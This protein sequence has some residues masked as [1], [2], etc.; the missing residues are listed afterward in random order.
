MTRD[1]C[2]RRYLSTLPHLDEGQGRD[3]VAFNFAAWLV[4][5]K[6]LPDAEALDWLEQWDAGN[7]PPKGRER[8]QE[9]IANAHA[10]GRR[11]YGSGNAPGNGQG[12]HAGPAAAEA[13]PF[14][15]G[16]L[17]LRL[18]GARKTPSRLTAKVVV[19]R[20]GQAIDTLSVT[21]SPSGRKEPVRLLAQHLGDAGVSRAE[22]DKTLGRI[23]M[24]ADAAAGKAGEREGE[25]ILELVGPRVLKDF[26]F[27]YRTE[28]GAYSE[29]RKREVRRQEFITY[30]PSDLV[31][32]CGEA[33]DA[34]VNERGVVLLPALVKAVG[35][36][37]AVVW[38]DLQRTLPLP[39]DADLPS[40]TAA[41]QA[42]RAAFLRVWEDTQTWER[43]ADGGAKRVNLARRA[44]D[45][46]ELHKGRRAGKMATNGWRQILESTH[47]WWRMY[48]GPDGEHYP[49]LAMRHSLATQILKQPLP[50]V[51]D[52]R[53]LTDLGVR[54]RVLD[55]NPPLN[56]FHKHGAERLAVLSRDVTEHLLTYAADLQDER[57]PGEDGP[58][59]RSDKP[60]K[61]D[62][63]RGASSEKDDAGSSAS[64]SGDDAPWR[65]K[66]DS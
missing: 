56:P 47:A 38:S 26:G 36:A 59:D 10:Y 15:L 5:D 39:A 16:P 52:Q 25:T 65:V 12:K 55:A 63:E 24:A 46:I 33:A 2:I 64:S 23:L 48:V 14:T 34:P 51:T 18:A 61:D 66:A 41:A 22:I 35:A 32:V 19:L 53:T 42:F 43:A 21:D 62:A 29:V 37:E 20:E 58:D 8:L 3:N 30:A 7:R 60:S 57:N 44:L 27:V 31:E 50:G 1:E 28:D 54:Y 13:A 11:A 40:D 6:Q 4:R 9:I 49:V 17:T 45:Q